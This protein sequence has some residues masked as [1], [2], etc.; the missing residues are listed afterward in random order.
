[1]PERLSVRGATRAFGADAGLFGLEV[2]L[3]AGEVHALIG[4]NGAGKTTLMRA[5]LG[6]L[7]LTDGTIEIDDTPLTRVPTAVWSR[8]GHLVEHPF[9]YPELDTR[10]NL[11]MA[12]RLHG[13][14]RSEERR[15]GKEWRDRRAA[16]R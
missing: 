12:A 10:T 16:C 2:T 3:A 9:A 11:E 13:A 8:V 6:M 7:R 5:I 1:M 14:D 4:L 15:V